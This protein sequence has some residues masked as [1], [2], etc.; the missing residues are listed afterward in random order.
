[1]KYRLSRLVEMEA[2]GKRPPGYVAAYRVAA[3]R[4]DADWLWVDDAAQAKLIETY[5][6]REATTPKPK[7]QPKALDRTKAAAQ[8]RVC[9]G[10]PER[11]GYTR[12]AFTAIVKCKQ[13]PCSCGQK[14]AGTVMLTKSACPLEKW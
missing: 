3:Y 1:M 12:R 2:S 13:Q 9:R 14:I 8:L 7:R 5:R 11:A 10:C 4:A 6:K